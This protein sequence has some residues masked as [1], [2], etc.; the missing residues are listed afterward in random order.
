MRHEGERK[1]SWGTY[2]LRKPGY[3]TFSGHA[4]KGSPSKS[5]GKEKKAADYIT[6]CNFTLRITIS[7]SDLN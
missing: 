4:M 1:Q 3:I 6:G 7:L 2:P 5:A